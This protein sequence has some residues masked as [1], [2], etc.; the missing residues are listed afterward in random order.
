MVGDGLFILWVIY[1]GIDEGFQ[2]VHLVQAVALGGLIVLLALNIFLLRKGSSSHAAAL[3]AG[4]KDNGAP[5]YRTDSSA[6]YYD[7]ISPPSVL[8]Y[9]SKFL[10]YIQYRINVWR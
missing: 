3:V 8:I 1:N 2:N 10:A 5:G 7:E 4:G 6:G 9:R